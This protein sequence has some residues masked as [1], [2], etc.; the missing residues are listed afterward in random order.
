MRTFTVFIVRPFGVKNDFDFDRVESDLIR[1]ALARLQERHG[2]HVIGGTTGEIVKQGNI[3]TDMFRLLINS[4]VVIADVSI[5]NANV[6]YELGI[7]HGLQERH[8]ILLRAEVDENNQYPF[9]LQSD[10][11]FLYDRA[12]LAAG[13]DSLV[14][15]LRTSLADTAKDSPVFQQLPKLR[16]HT[17][18][19][20][21]PA[22]SDL[23]DEIEV[24]VKTRDYGKL[25]LLAHEFD[26]LEWRS[27]GLRLVGNA[28]FNL[29]ANLG[30]RDTFEALRQTDPDDLLANQRLGTL[31]QRLCKEARPTDKAHLLT[32]SDQAI[33]RALTVAKTS[34][35][36]A[37]AFAL[38]G[39]NAKT[40]WIDECSAAVP[41]NLNEEALRSRYLGDALDAYLDAM[42]QQLNRHYPCINV[43]GLLKCQIALASAAPPVW[44]AP[45]DDPIDA[46]RALH[47]RKRT[48]DRVA[49]MLELALARDPILGTPVDLDNWALSSI[50][51]LLLLTRP[52]MTE[53]VRVAY[54][55]ALST[56]DM[57]TV[58]A[59][60]RNLEVYRYLGLFEPNTSAALDEISKLHPVVEPPPPERIVLFTGH[61]VDRSGRKPPR[62]PRTTEAETIARRLIDDALAQEVKEGPISLA[63]AGGACGGDILFHESC[64]VAGIERKLMLAVPPQQFQ[65]TSVQHGGAHWVERYLKLCR[66][67]APCVLQDSDTLPRWLA[68]RKDYD[69]WQRNNLWMMFTSLTYHAKHLTLIALYNPDLDPDGAGGTRHLLQ[70][71]RNH[72]FKIVE[73]D[74]RELLK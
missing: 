71:A 25:R 20:L 46:E 51:E 40:R 64:G 54:R 48:A 44:Q 61:M 1:P 32:L 14:E 60:R 21:M 73:L 36:R 42:R 35:D 26:G 5:H 8:T 66:E 29:K 43:L 57:F 52:E 68:G 59:T 65:V 72:S 30:A 10:R 45:Y 37:E 63:I 15:T 33:R 74:A 3:R 17:R 22:P 2:I 12:D 67:V 9:D 55:K 49:A 58:E 6:F 70:E 47:Y 16:P 50:A 18:A 41:S 4:D 13:I 7:R 24:A 34:A 19:E 39:S 38:L 62:F 53:A 31:Y 28:Q 56:A 23:Q 27:E 11:F 69:V